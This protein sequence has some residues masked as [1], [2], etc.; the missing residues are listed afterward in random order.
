MRRLSRLDTPSPRIVSLIQQRL[1]N[2][3]LQHGSPNALDELHE[4]HAVFRREQD[5]ADGEEIDLVA[6]SNHDILFGRRGNEE[7]DFLQFNIMRTHILT[8]LNETESHVL[9]VVGKEEG[10]VALVYLRKTAMK[11]DLENWDSLWLALRLHGYG[12][13]CRRI[14]TAC[15]KL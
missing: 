5:D 1:L 13:G 14:R 4:F 8:V 9:G 11:F 10:E 2:K 7:V 15:G 6:I 12:T 3:A